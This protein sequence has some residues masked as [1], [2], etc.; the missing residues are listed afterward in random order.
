MTALSLST[1]PPSAKALK[2]ISAYTQLI[3]DPIHK[4]ALADADVLLFFSVVL[5]GL[6]RGECLGRVA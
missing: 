3:Q 4:A 6:G 1:R 5:T 2:D